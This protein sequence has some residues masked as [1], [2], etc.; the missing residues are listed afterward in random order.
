MRPAVA[1]L[2]LAL[3]GLA[4][5]TNAIATI[6]A[7]GAK[8]FTSDGNQFFIKG[9]AYQLTNDD[10]LANG[11][12]CQ[13]DVALMKTIGT[14]AIRV[15][16]VDP[17][18]DHD[19]CMSAL[20]DAGI[21]T[22]IDLDT[23]STYIIGTDPY[24]TK[25]QY[26]AYSAVMDAFAGYDNVAGF[27]VGN[28][29]L[30]AGAQS[31]AAPYVKAAIRD[32][33][34]YRDNKN[35]RNFLVG[36]SAADIAELRP[37]L[38]NYL[39]CG[40]SDAERAD[41]FSLNA[42]E[43]CGDVDFQT[44]GYVG[45]E[46]S[47]SDYNI[48]L[49]FSETGCNVPVSSPRSFADQAAIL[50]PDMNENWSGAIIYEWIQ[51]ENDYGLISYGPTAGPTATGADVVAGFTRVGTPTPINPGWDN[52]SGQWATLSPTGVA[53]GAYNPSN[54]PPECPAFTANLWEVSGDVA[55][56]TMGSATLSGVAATTARRTTTANT[57]PSSDPS[58]GGATS[59]SSPSSGSA[60][61]TAS[62]SSGTGASSASIAATQTREASSQS[63]VSTSGITS[64]SAASTFATSSPAAFTSASSSAASSA[65][66][67]ATSASSS[68][69]SATTARATT[70]SS[71]SASSTSIT[72]ASVSSTT[73][74]SNV[75]TSTSGDPAASATP[76]GAASND[77]TTL[78]CII[79]GISSI[80]AFIA[81]L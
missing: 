77:L 16:H 75:L 70:A 8:L 49:F 17:T 39:A 45:L 18:A 13:Q 40:D 37:N 64:T 44:S 79:G 66:A 12:Q 65:S 31:P 53:M 38:Q 55:L 14:N 60:V 36:Y 23:F 61:S 68:T 5:V 76:T 29:V 11:A 15:Y 52:L 46:A 24:W 26:D 34:A 6:E 74:A 43:W 21:Y 22:W 19:A 28:E 3:S 2:A 25:G 30:N 71:A 57:S 59:G 69:A 51:E 81:L 48:P 33:K 63:S 73:A 35:Y 80:I 32:M 4:G 47:A 54:S 1:S 20:A 72:S 78:G 7:K 10:P 58:G 50:G 67:S 42:Y 62:S 41:F 27:F 9:I 56:P